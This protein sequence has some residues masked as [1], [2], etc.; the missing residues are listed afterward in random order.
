MENE[1]SFTVPHGTSLL[2]GRVVELLVHLIW[3]R[4]CPWALI[5]SI[6]DTRHPC[7][8][9]PYIWILNHLM[10]RL[11]GYAALQHYGVELPWKVI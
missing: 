4:D 2:A 11:R 10:A 6:I 1:R 7:A 3:G 9:G 8:L 5:C